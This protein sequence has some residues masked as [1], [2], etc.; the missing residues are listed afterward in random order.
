MSLRPRDDGWTPARQRAFLEALASCGSVAT[1]ARR[2]GMSRESAYAL[3]RRSDARG[4][5]QA[6]DAA[7]LLAAEH[8]V[9]LAWDRAVQGEVRPLV[10]HGEVVGEVRHYDNRLLLGL[11][12]QNRKVLVEQGLAD[13]PEVTAAVAA[14]WD[15]ALTRAEQ[16]QFLPVPGRG[17][18]PAGDGGGARAGD[19]GGAGRRGLDTLPVPLHHP[20]DGPPPP[21]G[22]DLPAPLLPEPDGQGGLI[23]E[24]G[25]LEVGAYAIWWQADH[26]CWLTNWPAPAGWQGEEFRVGSDGAVE[27]WDPD[28]EADSATGPRDDWART[29][30][31]EEVA[32]AERQAAEDAAQ[33]AARLE[34]YRRRA[35]DLATEAELAS[36]DRAEQAAEIFAP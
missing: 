31:S 12:A 7:R 10:Y 21:A 27:P 14:D 26:N 15:A 11:I 33:V 2:V 16:G 3:R 29:L 36:L 28:E 20:A 30:T 8:L 32:G 6:W 9:D 35:I 34:L 4:F 5:A 25:Q 13:P 22:E 18:I 1:A 23:D 17:T 24:A 19:P